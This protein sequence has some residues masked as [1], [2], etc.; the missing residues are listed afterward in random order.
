MQIQNK[1]N[2]R[3]FM[4]RVKNFQ[5]V[6]V[7]EYEFKDGEPC[8][9]YG[10]N[11]A[12][13]SGNIHGIYMAFKGKG[14]VPVK[15]DHPVGPYSTSV[16][17]KATVDIGIESDHE[18]LE[19]GGKSLKKLYVHFSITEKG[20]ISLKVTDAVTGNNTS[21][22]R[23]KIEQ[24]LGMFV[25]PVELVKTLEEP[26]GDRLLAEKLAAMRGQ[27]LKP[28][29]VKDEELFSDLQGENVELKRQQGE[30]ASLD[31]PQDDWATKYTDPALISKQLQEFNE[32]EKQ[33]EQRIRNIQEAKNSHISLEKINKGLIDEIGFISSDVLGMENDFTKQKEK[34]VEDTESF[35]TFKE[36][37]KPVE[38]TGTKDIEEEIR[39]LT[40]E[41]V[42]YRQ[43]EQ[44]EQR[45]VQALSEKLRAIEMSTERLSVSKNNLD[46]KTV[47]LK[48]KK[49]EMSEHDQV[50]ISSIS[51]VDQS[52]EENKPKKWAGEI[53]PEGNKEPSEYLN[54][55]MSNITRWNTEFENRKRYTKADEGIKAVETS[56][57]DIK[58]K[59]KENSAEKANAVSSMKGKFPHPGITIDFKNPDIS[60]ISDIKKKNDI[61]VWVDMDDRRGPRT[62][63][64]LSEGEQL[65]ICTHILIAGNT[66]KLNIL[67][68]RNGNRLDSDM[69]RMVYDI[70]NENGYDVILETIETSEV[71]ALHIVDGK[72][73]S[74]NQPKDSPVE[75]TVVPVE[76]KKE[77]DSGIN[78]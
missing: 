3:V 78:W 62:I 59:R 63:N 27:D 60:E 43:Y 61:T 12:G 11:G 33:N 51:G 2:A 57:Q 72:V 65:M 52:I 30:F 4:F 15:I 17:K 58:K 75:K 53:D 47:L 46:E 7:V 74:I 14:G 25:D 8:I 50:V 36:E 28:F 5:G 64:D 38:W 6:E 66:G 19:L 48:Q 26:N 22:P 69:Q 32:F 76:E 21:A 68:V 1:Q 10:K 54:S 39:K 44:G 29:A 42:L 20:S 24:L 13:K 41:L 31:E 56:I 67:L 16:I 73:E 37:N 23:E 49:Q 45:K 77:D 40:E 70:A 55:K 34:Y 9:L 71:G 35:R 18:I